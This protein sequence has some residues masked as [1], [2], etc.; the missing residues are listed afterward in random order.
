[1]WKLA[2]KGEQ[3]GRGVILG[4]TEQALVRHFERP[5][6][7]D[8]ID[9]AVT[10]KGD[11][12]AFPF[13]ADGVKRAEHAAAHFRESLAIRESDPSGSMHPTGV[14]LGVLSRDFIE[15]DTF[16]ITE[17]YF[18]QVCRDFDGTGSRGGKDSRAFE[19]PGLRTRID[20]SNAFVAEVFGNL[21]HLRA[22]IFGESHV[23]RAV[24]TMADFVGRFAVP[25]QP[26]TRH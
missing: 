2:R 25:D 9:T 14:E 22:A 15:V 11:G 17:V 5:G 26:K 20:G 24:A 4:Q 3:I 23:Q 19:R 8:A 10:D 16:Q 18:A 21:L 12:L 7:Q 6:K 1:M 13:A